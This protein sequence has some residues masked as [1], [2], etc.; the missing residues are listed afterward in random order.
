MDSLLA[1]L[2]LAAYAGLAFGLALPA[3]RRPA[4]VILLVAAGASLG[5]G[6][7]GPAER[8]LETFCTYAGFQGTDQEISVVRFPTGTATASG[9]LWPLPYAAFAAGWIVALRR[10]GSTALRSPF[11]A[12][13]AF[14]WSATAA[15]LSMQTL[16]A[17]SEV[18]QPFGLDRFLFPAGL[19]AALIAARTCERFARAFLSV[20][21]VALLGR[22]PAA[23]FSKIASD[24]GLGTCLDTGR[25]RDIVN[26]V[27]QL[28]F[29]PRLVPGS[30][31]HQFW[32]IWL[33]H[34]IMLP[35]FYLMSLTGIA[36]GVFMFHHHGK[37][38]K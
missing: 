26:P 35:A 11:V 13:L 3:A 38:P 12:P 16:A 2:H 36:F 8:T 32:L 28:Q 7:L 31:A 15:W 30:G 17:P 9:F 37:Q 4:I 6:M 19:A 27:T 10:L 21:A 14:A 33:E 5:A 34:V 24:Q 25:V 29:E 23:L 22:L 20:G 1:L 18:V